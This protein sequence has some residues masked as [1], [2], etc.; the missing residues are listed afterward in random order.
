MVEV[1]AEQHL[2]GQGLADDVL[3]LGEDRP[4]EASHVLEPGAEQLGDLGRRHT[5]ADVRLD[6]TGTGA[7]RLG[8]VVAV[9]SR[10]A[11]FDPQYVVD[12]EREPLA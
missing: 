4:F 3:A 12:V 5:G 1:A 8:V 2:N 7:G 6:L 11:Q 9:T 10:L